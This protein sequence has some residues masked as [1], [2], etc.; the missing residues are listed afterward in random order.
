MCQGANSADLVSEVPILAASGFSD[1]S[2]PIIVCSDCA[3]QSVLGLAPGL[4]HEN[5]AGLALHG[6]MLSHVPSRV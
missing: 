3:L 5:A 2:G 4:P 1:A 6:S